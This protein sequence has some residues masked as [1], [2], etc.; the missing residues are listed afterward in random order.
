MAMDLLKNEGEINEKYKLN[1][2]KNKKVLD[3]FTTND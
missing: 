2:N 3:I 1:T